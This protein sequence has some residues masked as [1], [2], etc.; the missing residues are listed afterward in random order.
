MLE[1]IRCSREMFRL[2]LDPDDDINFWVH[3]KSVFNREFHSMNTNNHNLALFL[4]PMCRKLAI[5]QAAKGRSFDK[6]CRA[7]LGIARQ[8]H[9]DQQRAGR[10]AEDLKLYYHCKAPFIG[11]EWDARAWWEGL[12]ISLD[13]HPLKSLAIT[14]HSVVPHSADVERLFSD[15]GGVQGVKRCKLTV[16]TFETLGK[17]RANYAHHLFERDHTTSK[18]TRRKHAH[19]HTRENRG[20]DVELVT[21]LQENFT[22]TPPLSIRNPDDDLA[23]PESITDEDIDTA[24][25]ELEKRSAE[26]SIDP[27]L[28]DG[29]IMTEGAR[30]YDFE[31]FDRVERG[32]VPK[33]FD[34]DVENFV[35]ASAGADWDIQSLLASKGVSSA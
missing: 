21:D 1:L 34:E 13:K 20:I 2:P 11:G 24:F 31:E 4:H 22:W 8:W 17:L 29:D 19:M 33:A 32:M 9:W 6:V 15:L 28:E 30:A 10:L 12:E 16:H 23:G 14:I 35:V 5:S 27:E 3:A 25:D 18:S 26:S 7:A